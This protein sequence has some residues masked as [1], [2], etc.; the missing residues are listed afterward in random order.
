MPPACRSVIGQSDAALIAMETGQYTSARGLLNH[1]A[2]WF[3]SNPS[4]EGHADVLDSL[5]ILDMYGSR[6]ASASRRFDDAVR[7]YEDV[8]D[9]TGIGWVCL[10]QS[11]LA[12]AQ[13]LASAALDFAQAAYQAGE[14]LGDR[15]LQGWAD[16]R[17]TIAYLG[18]GRTQEARDRSSR[19]VS[20]LRLL[21]DQRLG[22]LTLEAFAAIAVTEGRY[23]HALSLD[24]A[25]KRHR[26]RCGIPRSP[27]EARMFGPPIERAAAVLDEAAAD[28]ARNVGRRWNLELALTAAESD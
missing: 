15:V 14:E 20:L 8:N 28:V 16:H 21:G 17:A 7:R 13:G 19:C 4:A 2:E 1:A 6:Y 3:T 12:S 11:A 10:D 18:L 22:I 5:G 27:S 26:D 9:R 24:E 23:A 25:A